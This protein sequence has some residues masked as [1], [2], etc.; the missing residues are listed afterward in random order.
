MKFFMIA[1][2]YVVGA[3]ILLVSLLCI[4]VA[5]VLSVFELPKYLRHMHK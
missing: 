5:G 3:V 4:F 1:G 2:E